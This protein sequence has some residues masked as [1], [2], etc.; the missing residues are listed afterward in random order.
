MILLN[1]LSIFR[2]EIEYVNF[3]IFDIK[4]N[5]NNKFIQLCEN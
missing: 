3:V 4:S 2:T 5:K 1:I